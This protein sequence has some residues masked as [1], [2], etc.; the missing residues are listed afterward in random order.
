MDIKDVIEWF[1]IA[2][3]DFDSAK[4]LNKASR[5]HKEIICYH[6]A[7]AI[8]KYLKG[9]LTYND[10]IPQRNHNII[11]LN[12]TCIELGQAFKQISNECGLLNKFTNEIR[13]PYRIEIKEE[14]V[15]Y[16][17][18]AVERIRNIEPI[19]NL[20]NFLIK[21]NKIQDDVKENKNE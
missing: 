4:I 1:K 8:E 18:N 13:Y 6:C 11:L 19:L 16:A 5:K 17:L 2:D 10:I 14:D 21:E 7:Q 12:E 9:Y 3:E 15:I 20:R